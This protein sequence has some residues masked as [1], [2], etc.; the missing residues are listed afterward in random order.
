[1]LWIGR[2]RSSRQK[3]PLVFASDC[4]PLILDLKSLFQQFFL[5]FPS[6]F[7]TNIL[8]ISKKCCSA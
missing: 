5:C 4:S 1:V 6:I 8:F 7:N 2:C 3:A